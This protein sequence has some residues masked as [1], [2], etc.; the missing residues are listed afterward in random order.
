[1]SFEGRGP[2]RNPRRDTRPEACHE[3]RKEHVGILYR[4]AEIR[5]RVC[6]SNLET[7]SSDDPT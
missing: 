2:R 6:R 4:I 7:S 1:M 5:G 3:T